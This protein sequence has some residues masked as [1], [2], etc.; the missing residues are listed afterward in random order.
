MQDRK[1]SHLFIKQSK[2]DSYFRVFLKWFWLN[3]MSGRTGESQTS[4]CTWALLVTVC[5]CDATHAWRVLPGLSH[6]ITETF[7]TDGTYP[8]KDREHSCSFHLSLS[9]TVGWWFSFVL[10]C[11]QVHCGCLS[12]GQAASAHCKKREYSES[13]FLKK[14]VFMWNISIIR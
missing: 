8:G 5:A 2:N 9:G 13:F 14:R 6:L 12:N 4:F 7:D 3:E 11:I 1:Y 10:K